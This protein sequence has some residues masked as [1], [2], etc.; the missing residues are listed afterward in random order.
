MSSV[1]FSSQPCYRY[2]Y[3]AQCILSDIGPAIFWETINFSVFGRGFL[4]TF[5]NSQIGLKMIPNLA[6]SGPKFY[7]TIYF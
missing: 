4:F 3:V 2:Y 1:P 7:Q 5:L 6:S